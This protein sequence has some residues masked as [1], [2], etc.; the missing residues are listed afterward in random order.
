MSTRAHRGIGQALEVVVKLLFGFV[1][2]LKKTEL[3]LLKSLLERENDKRE[4]YI[5]VC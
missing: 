2:S 5:R 3:N 1:L 4:S